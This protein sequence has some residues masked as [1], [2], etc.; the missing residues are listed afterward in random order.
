MGTGP[1]RLWGGLRHRI[2]SCRLY[3]SIK[4]KQRNSLVHV[5]YDV[6]VHVYFQAVM[7]HVNQKL[8]EI[9]DIMHPC[10]PRSLRVYPVLRADA[11]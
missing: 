8:R 10:K 5:N 6:L 11:G 9:D 3:F 7:S 2:T 4:F 1:L